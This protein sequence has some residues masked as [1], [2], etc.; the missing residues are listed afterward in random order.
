MVTS[1]TIFLKHNCLVHMNLTGGDPCLGNAG[2]LPVGE[3]S[4]DICLGYL[5][6]S[7]PS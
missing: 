4:D 3:Q 1:T 6:N 5:A 2:A 7:C